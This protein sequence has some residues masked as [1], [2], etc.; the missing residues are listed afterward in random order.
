L[1]EKN[2]MKILENFVLVEQRGKE[3]K[4]MFQTLTL[5]LNPMSK[6]KKNRP[7]KNLNF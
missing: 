7:K 4:L 1:L 3:V 2:E 6:L 5:K